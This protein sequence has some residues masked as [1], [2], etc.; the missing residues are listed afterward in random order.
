MSVVIMAVDHARPPGAAEARDGV[1]LSPAVSYLIAKLSGRMG[2][3]SSAVER[4]VYTE[5]AGGS[6]QSPPIPCAE[7]MARLDDERGGAYTPRAL[8]RV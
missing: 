4:L 6:N 7:C 3:V 5:R 8:L 1:P 2:A